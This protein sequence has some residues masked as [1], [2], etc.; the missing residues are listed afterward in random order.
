MAAVL[1]GGGDAALSHHSAAELWGFGKE[2]GGLIEIS[3]P[4]SR[5][6]R[7]SEVRAHRRRGLTASDVVVRDGIPVTSPIRTLID[8]SAPLDRTGFERALSEAD[9]LDLIHPDE[10]REA[11][12]AYAGQPGV[13]RLRKFL[14][15]RTFRLTDSEL[16]RRFFAITDSI[17][18]PRPL[19]QQHING[20]RVDFHCPDLGLVIETDGL[21]YH[22]TPAQQA[23]DRVRDQTHTAA[24][25]TPLRFTHEQV[26]WDPTFVRRI[27]T[28]VVRRIE[29]AAA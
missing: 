21:R 23:R 7:Q 14:D 27:M 17:G 5:T 26:R 29:D 18:L 28:A 11:L 15:R 20:F 13:G 3:I 19:T 2:R 16:E 8:I 6:S 24:G 25:L 1:A 9:R 4:A 22:R 10:L 12:D